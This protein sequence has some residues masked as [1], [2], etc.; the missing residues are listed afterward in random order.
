MKQRETGQKLME[1]WLGGNRK[2]VELEKVLSLETNRKL[3]NL[4]AQL[5]AK[6]ASTDPVS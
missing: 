5:L 6:Q 3:T 2:T 1:N 4:S